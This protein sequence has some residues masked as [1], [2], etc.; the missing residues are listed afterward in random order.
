MLTN[1]GKALIITAILHREQ[2][3]VS[4]FKSE[5]SPLWIP[6][7]LGQLEFSPLRETWLVPFYREL[8]GGVS[9]SDFEDR[10]A[11]NTFIIFNYDR[12]FEHF[13]I[14]ALKEYDQYSPTEAVE[15]FNRIKIIHPYGKIAELEWQSDAEIGVSFGDVD[16]IETALQNYSRIQTFME[17]SEK[18]LGDE[19]LEEVTS[20]QNLVFLGFGY[21]DQNLE[22]LGKGKDLTRSHNDSRRVFGTCYGLSSYQEVKA[23]RALA[24][25]L[26]VDPR[27][28]MRHLLMSDKRVELLNGTCSDL[29]NE[30]GSEWFG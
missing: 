9:K 3:P 23:R 22:L 20:A 24:P 6:E 12:C 1:L 2:T 28:E 8:R 4:G 15:V 26:L 16:A 14:H 21:A 11:N 19:I 17:S 13:M 10:L 25:F 7:S 29:I 5:G 27:P 18:E 30:Y